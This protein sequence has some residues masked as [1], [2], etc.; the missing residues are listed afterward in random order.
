MTDKVSRSYK[1]AETVVSAAMSLIY[2]VKVNGRENIPDGAAMLCANHS[3]WTDPLL[4]MYAARNCGHLHIMAK[5]ELFKIIGLNWILRWIGSFPVDRKN[6]DI[7]A[8]KTTM[9]YLK[10]GDK[11]VIFPEG[12]RSSCDNEVSAKSGAVRIADRMNAPVVPIYIPRRKRLFGTVEIVIGEPYH[13]NTGR[14]KLCAQDYNV[15]AEQ[16]MYRIAA[17]RPGG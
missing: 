9:K 7:A 16:L 2:R 13:I 10:K 11:I 17:L 14:L 5:K 3:N 4:I 6:A 8:V 15:L 1:F 12:T